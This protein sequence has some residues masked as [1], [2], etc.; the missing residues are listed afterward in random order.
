MEGLLTYP[1]D[2]TL[3]ACSCPAPVASHSHTL[4]LIKHTAAWG[5]AEDTLSASDFRHVRSCY[6]VRYL[7]AH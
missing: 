2:W 4:I 5:Q 3:A 7:E 6:T 1:P